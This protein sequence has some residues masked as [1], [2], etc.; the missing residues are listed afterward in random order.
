MKLMYIDYSFVYDP[1][2]TFQYMYEFESML[3]DFLE[4]KGL[5]AEKISSFVP[6]GK[7]IIYIK[8]KPLMEQIKSEE[9]YDPKTSKVKM[10]VKLPKE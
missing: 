2:E 7:C 3:D 5:E 9:P 4:S 8:K 10:K 1:A 6:G